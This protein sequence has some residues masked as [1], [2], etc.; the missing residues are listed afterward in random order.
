MPTPTPLPSWPSRTV[1]VLATLGDDG[2]H[3]IP[4]STALH[5]G[6][7][8]VLLALASGRGSLARLRRDP[9]VA[10]LILSEGNV[11]VT[12]Q[13][14]ADGFV[15]S[16]DSA[17]DVVVVEL[18]IERVQDHRQPTFEIERG[19]SWRWTDPEAAERDARVRAE[20]RALGLH[21]PKA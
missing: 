21:R 4:V 12:L 11:A 5:A 14:R 6:P 3:A 7:D 18:A 2:P 9:R 17:P 20:L 15:D 1:A 8:R 16:L 19:V 10:L 13:G